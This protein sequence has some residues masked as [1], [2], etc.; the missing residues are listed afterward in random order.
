MKE[1]GIPFNSVLDKTFDTDNVM[2]TP[3]RISAVSMIPEARV[4]KEAKDAAKKMVMM[5]IRV[6]NRP[7]QGTKLFVSMAMSLSRGDW[8][9]RQPVT[10]QALH[11]NPMHMD[12]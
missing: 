7:L 12:G 5:A 9:M 4:R 2:V 6:G 8:M 11:P 1:D 10:P 3:S